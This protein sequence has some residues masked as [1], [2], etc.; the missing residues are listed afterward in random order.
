M[1][2]KVACRCRIAYRV[3]NST[4]S[5]LAG[6]R[7]LEP[8][9]GS[10]QPA[11]S[12]RQRLADMSGEAPSVEMRILQEARESAKAAAAANGAG[13]RARVPSI[14]A[15]QAAGLVEVEGAQWMSQEKHQE[16]AR[17]LREYKEAARQ[18]KEYNKQLKAEAA[19]QLASGQHGSGV[20]QVIDG[21]GG[22]GDGGVAS[23]GVEIGGNGAPQKSVPR[24]A[25]HQPGMANRS[26]ITAE[27][28]ETDLCGGSNHSKRSMPSGS[29]LES[30]GASERKRMRS[31][32][33]GDVEGRSNTTSAPSLVEAAGNGGGEHYNSSQPRCNFEQCA[34]V[35]CYGVHGIARYW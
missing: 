27:V 25:A 4:H 34:E 2:S 21:S 17:R 22:N 3:C 16:E 9:P 10:P 24:L 14:K 35:A 1:R 29:E 20:V 12:L 13:R 18:Y 19:A 33:V 6:K 7:G 11:Q 32:E 30:D 28:S 8:Y 23:G 26:I 15:L 5:T 31:A